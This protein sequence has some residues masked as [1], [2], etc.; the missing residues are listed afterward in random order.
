ME[1]HV[2][3][4]S[5][6]HGEAVTEEQPQSAELTADAIASIQAQ[7]AELVESAAASAAAKKDNA[8]KARNKRK[9]AARLAKVKAKNKEEV[10]KAKKGLSLGTVLALREAHNAPSADRTR[11]VLRDAKRKQADA[12]RR[13]NRLKV[14]ASKV[15][16]QTS[17]IDDESTVTE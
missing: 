15:S 7:I 6:H 12:M 10:R 4:E 8:R 16:E 17:V 3:S 1:H 11:K 5:C 9:G 14:T 2:H 13:I